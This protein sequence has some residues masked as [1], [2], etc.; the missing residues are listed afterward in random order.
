MLC[1]R[2]L[3]GM[4]G[5]LLLLVAAIAPVAQA[6]SAE[7]KFYQAYFLERER[8]DLAAAAAVYNEVATDRKADANLQAQARVRGQACEEELASADFAKLMPPNALAYVELSRPGGQLS[9]LLEM[10]GL[11]REDGTIVGDPERRLAISPELIRELLGIR[12]IAAAVT[13]FDPASEMPTGVAILHPGDINVIRGLIETALPA[14]GQIVEPIEGY[15][16]FNIEGQVFVTLTQRLVIVSAQPL[17]I[18]GV[19]GRLK[20]E[21]PES[22]ANN[23]ALAEVMRQRD[24]SLLFFCVNFEP[25]MPLLNA[26]LAAAGTQS[27]ELA[28]AQALLDL[29]S[30]RTLV[31]QMGVNDEGIYVDFALQLAEGHRNLAFQ[32][33][34]MPA[35]NPD[36]L[37]RIPAGAAGFFAGALNDP[38][39]Q[40]VA[41]RT[42]GR[43]QPPPVTFLDIGREIFANIVSFAIFAVPADEQLAAGAP[44]IPPVAAVITV[45]DPVK[46]Q[47]LWSQMLGV[48]SLAS[49]AGTLDGLKTEIAGVA[50]QRYIFPEGIS[51]YLAHAGNDML[52][53]PSKAAIASSLATLKGGQSILSDPA[54]AKNL[55]RLGP[56]ATFALY[57]HPGRCVELAKPFMSPSDLAEAQP[58]VDL[59][60]DTVAS[61][62]MEHSSNAF[63][64]STMVTGLPDIGPFVSKMITIEQQRDALQSQLRQARKHGQWDEALATVREMLKQQPDNLDL[65]QSEFEILATGLRDREAALVVAEKVFEAVRDNATLLNNY[66]WALL[67]EEGKFG[68]DYAV[69]ALKL[70]QRSN[71][72]TN[73]QNWRF[74]DTLALAFFK[75]GD[76]A[77]AVEMEKKALALCG[78]GPGRKDVEVA[79]QR[80]QAAV[81]Q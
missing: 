69:L 25:V 44:P 7:S 54:F 57:A 45:H 46:S 55:K 26:G 21:D 10:L 50:A 27:R 23:P 30:L 11:L 6:Q 4:G 13:S 52:I 81:E 68:D 59:M 58:I 51:I 53:S 75:T 73:H 12:G 15:P 65:L 67:T 61:V 9:R 39:S 78:D 43:D 40:Y 56:N 62:V 19:I 17:E 22:L 31:G 14:G 35:I 29:K 41:A 28:M 8:G 18:E 47:A 60:T 34:R 80:F 49:G 1:T 77:Q 5:G 37:K 42:A 36:T 74:V 24:P 33:M 38:D 76:A 72:L 16:T 66:A 32:F 79:L 48:G 64:F 71:E 70:S 63:H 20:G 3:Q 2:V